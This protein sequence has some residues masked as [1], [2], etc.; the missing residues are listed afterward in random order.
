[1]EVGV[2][3]ERCEDMSRYVA[4]YRCPLCGTH[5]KYG[6]AVE[7]P[8]QMLAEILAKVVRNQQ[9]IGSGMYVAPLYIPH[10]CSNGNAGL[11]QFVGLTK[12]GGL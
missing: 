6:D 9:F 12:E 10:K 1:M 3:P 4:T 8:E 7:C 11:A 2:L 5:L